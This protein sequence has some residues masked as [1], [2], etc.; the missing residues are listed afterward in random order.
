[1]RRV[2]VTFLLLV[3]ASLWRLASAQTSYNV[4]SSGS[5][6][7]YTCDAWI[8]DFNGPTGYY[9]N[10]WDGY[11]VI[12]PSTSGFKVSISSGTYDV[13]STFDHVYVYNG[14]GTGGTQLLDL[15][16]SNMSLN[17]PVVSTDPTG[18]LTVRFTTDGSL[19]TYEGFKL[20]VQCVEPVAMSNTSLTNC[21]MAWMDP[22]GMGDYSNNQ[23][24]TQT[25]CSD[26]GDH[27]SVSFSSFS[28]LSGDYLYVYDGNS[29]TST[30]LGSYT[31]TTLPPDL[32][33][34]GD[35]LTFRFVSNG[36]GVSSG[37]IAGISCTA[38]VQA[39]NSSGSPCMTGGIHPFCTD[40]GQY[41]YCS[42]VSGSAASFFGTGS[43]ACLYT[44][45]APAWYFMRIDH[46]GNMTIHIE[47]HDLNGGG[48]D[49][50]FACWGPFSATSSADFVDKLCSNAYNLSN[51]LVDC[52]YS[53][54]A[55]ENCDILNAQAGQY[56][57]LLITNYSQDPGV[58]TFNS[59]QGSGAT[60][61][62]SLMSEVSNDGPYCEGDTVRLFCNNQ[63]S[64]SSY[65]WS[66]PDGWSS[67]DANPVVGL[68]TLSMSGNTYSLVQTLNGSASDTATT[69]IV[70]N[71]MTTSA[72]V[73]PNPPICPGNTVTLTANCDGIMPVMEERFNTLTA[74]GDLTTTGSTGPSNVTIPNNTLASFPTMSYVYEAG[75]KV[76]LGKRNNGDAIGSM[77]SVPLDLSSPFDVII[78]AKRWFNNNGVLVV[79][80]AGQTSQ[81]QTVSTDS[82][83]DYIFHFNAATNASPIT[84]STHLNGIRLFIDSIA[85]LRSADCSV[86]WLPGGQTTDVI[87]VSPSASTTYILQQTLGGCE[88]RDTIPITV[89]EPSHQSDTMSTCCSSYRWP[90]N[91]ETYTTSGIYRYEHTDDYGCLQVD[92]LHLTL[93]TSPSI[94]VASNHNPYGECN[95]EIVPP[96]F[97]CTDPCVGSGSF[98][99][100]PSNVTVSDIQITGFQRRQTWTAHYTNA[101][102][103][104]A[105]SRSITY[106]WRET[107]EQFVP[108][109]DLYDT[110]CHVSEANDDTIPDLF[111]CD[112]SVM[113]VP[114]SVWDSLINGCGDMGYVYQ[115]EVNGNDYTWTHHYHILPLSTMDTQVV[116]CGPFEWEGELLAHD[117]VVVS[118]YEAANGCDSLVRMTLTVHY[119]HNEY[120]PVVAF[121]QY[122]WHDSVYRE[123]G[124]Y[125]Y[126]HMDDNGCEQVDTLFLTVY[127]DSLTELSDTACDAYL[128]NNTILTTSGDY[129]QHLTNIHNTDSTVI[130]H[131]TIYSHKDTT[132][133]RSV[134]YSY[135]W[136][137]SVYTET[138]A[139]SQHFQT[140]NGCD[141]IVNLEL[142]IDYNRDTVIYAEACQSY[143]W[144]DSVYTRTGIYVQQFESSSRCDSTV[145][146][147]LTVNDVDSTEWYDT[148]CDVKQWN[149][150][151]YTES[152]SYVQHFETIHGCDSAVTLHL[153]VFHKNRNVLDSMVCQSRLP[154]VWNEI[155]FQ[156]AGVDSTVLTSNDGCDS[157]VVMRLHVYSMSFSTLYD[158]IVQNALPY[159][160][161]GMHFTEAGTL[162]DT[163]SSVNGC[164]SVVTMHLTVLPNVMVTVD[165]T[166]CEN[167]LPFSW[168][169]VLFT[170]SDTLSATLLASNGADSVVVM[171]LKV[172]FNTDTVLRTE[173]V[174]NDLPVVFHGHS[175]YGPVS[176]DTVVI[177]NHH[178]CDSIIIYSLDVRMNVRDTT[179]LILCENDLPYLWN[180]VMFTG[181]DTQQVTLL[182]TLG[183]DSLL[184][185][186]LNVHVNTSSALFDT[187]VEN[188]LPYDTLGM[189]FVEAGILNDTIANANGCD[190]IITMNLHV[191]NNVSNTIDTLVCESYLPV[192]WNDV[193]FTRSGD[194]TITLVGNHGVDSTL[195]M[196]LSVIPTD[197]IVFQEEVCE[198]KD[199]F[200]H[201]FVVPGS[202]TVNVIG[203]HL[204]VENTFQNAYGCDSVVQ[205]ELSIVDTF[206]YVY[207]MMD[208]CENQATILSAVS[209]LTDY[210]WSTGD[211]TQSIEVFAPGTYTVT[212]SQGDC[213]ASSAYKVEKCNVALF[214]PNAITPGRLDGRNDCFSLPVHCRNQMEDFEITILNRWGEVVFHTNDT[215]FSWCGEYEGDVI[216][217]NVYS[218][219]IHYRDNDHHHNK[220]Q[221]KG[222][223]T[224]L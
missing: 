108:V 196:H 151:V 76:K 99:L 224:V 65:A 2:F 206:L 148:V 28:L 177:Q 176:N 134:C 150:S 219:V 39:E 111:Y 145:L 122:F 185:M 78:R 17:T 104:A 125:V 127:H 201:G 96:T 10:Y 164:D 36:S 93:G 6:T 29:T 90:R 129:V 77:T 7:V 163:I 146:L 48:I 166:I 24:V 94:T 152:G 207:P 27:L 216:R 136:N 50:D 61:D 33:S 156:D 43:V 3:L 172:K 100:P 95:P 68:A 184:T 170:R 208:F 132:I 116:S 18:A 158:T 101:C 140:A 60:T 141:S 16:G 49:V 11:L 5:Q 199:Y 13:E 120:Y 187:I 84:I 62:C 130:L 126:A 1:M 202:Q 89:R 85:I 142:T 154:L 175:Y 197:V 66:G 87:S 137:D 63:Q 40:E 157:L 67:T 217:Q 64:G 179:E 182:T 51:H 180:N 110:I 171:M 135:Q 121:N 80:V 115:Y 107:S 23:D 26:N 167:N 118:W 4:P 34:S 181:P 188:R 47:Q 81:T 209:S 205:L 59:T 44:T 123:S 194:S 144:N 92:T 159:D 58:I 19:C 72:A 109:P 88:R 38:C 55:T 173:V 139:Y 102:G 45:P 200:G 203:N 30:L 214:L 211:I 46:P 35:C 21:S 210:V 14:V 128:W 20:R 32:V 218:Y 204:S 9:N 74:G 149:D 8:Y 189:H 215:D 213:Q 37:W 119:P 98:L 70:V 161:L 54:S 153:T 131:L 25:I 191:W 193:L 103:D 147:Y 114:V 124:L 53:A 56:Y 162:Q 183:T 75:G 174:E 15:S 117:T 113:V 12:Y 31:G 41:T 186:I 105:A 221:V 86:L 143:V 168:N 83:Q 155:T 42:G 165:S 73:S 178:G 112:E 138:G 79:S 190:S 91:G 195:T 169:N 220:H 160:T 97:L 212:A 71:R 82:Y 52:S 192:V 198:G 22:G 69:T 223:I 57:L 222:S 133:Y 106:T